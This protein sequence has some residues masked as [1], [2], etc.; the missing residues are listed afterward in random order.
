MSVSSM[1]GNKEDSI[2]NQITSCSR[3]VCHLLQAIHSKDV[4]REMMFSIFG[5]ISSDNGMKGNG[6]CK[7]WGLLAPHFLFGAK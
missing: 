7:S 3:V 1:G 6:L 4:L 5:F 2:R